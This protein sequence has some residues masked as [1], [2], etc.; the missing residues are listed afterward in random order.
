MEFYKL[1]IKVLVGAVG[2]NAYISEAEIRVLAGLCV[3]A[4][5]GLDYQNTKVGHMWIVKN[6]IA[7]IK[8]RVF[9]NYKTKLS[10][11]GW[12]HLQRGELRFCSRLRSI[13]L[14]GGLGIGLIMT[15]ENRYS[16]VPVKK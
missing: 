3:M 15:G 5:Q 4:S 12:I 10:K 14:T 16:E 7:K 13:L 8:P 2:G 1:C 6:R 9:Q 11:S